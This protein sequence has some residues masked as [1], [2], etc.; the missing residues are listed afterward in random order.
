MAVFYTWARVGAFW[1]LPAE[2]FST[3]PVDNLGATCVQ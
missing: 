2:V 3:G 1:D